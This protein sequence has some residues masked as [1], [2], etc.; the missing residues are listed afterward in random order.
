[1]SKFTKFNIIRNS[2]VSSSSRMFRYFTDSQLERI[3]SISPEFLSMFVGFVDGDGCFYT[4]QNSA[5]SL[6]TILL[7]KLSKLDTKTL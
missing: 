4:R 6:E 2:L 1:M 3:L 7:I 5:N